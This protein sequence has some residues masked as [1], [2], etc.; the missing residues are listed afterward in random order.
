MII[1]T[2]IVTL[3]LFLY[4]FFKMHSC[5]SIEFS[6]Y[7]TGIDFTTSILV[8]PNAEYYPLARFAT[9][10]KN[11]NVTFQITRD[12]SS[13]LSVSNNDDV[14]SYAEIYVSDGVIY[15]ETLIGDTGNLDYY[16]MSMVYKAG[17]WTSFLR[18][19]YF[20]VS[21]GSSCAYNIRAFSRSYK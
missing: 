13:C 16:E 10:N 18:A 19:P 9:Y 8:P 4:F 15:S 17:N 3:H 5:S 2:A 20:S 11:V 1:V 21:T 12:S 6:T 14:Q 7:D